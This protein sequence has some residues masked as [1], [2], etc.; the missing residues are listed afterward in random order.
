MFKWRKTSDLDSKSVVKS[1]QT[2]TILVLV[3]FTMM[4]FGVCQP[5]Q[6]GFVMPSGTAASVDGDKITSTEFRRAYI[7]YSNQLQQQYRDKFDPVALGVSVQVLN[8]LVD[9]AALYKEGLKS[10][11]Y[12][13]DEEI[14]HMIIDGEYFKDEKGGK[15]DPERFKMYLKS[16]G[17]TEATFTEELRREIVTNKFRGLITG[18]FQPSE[19]L[20]ELNYQLD[21]TKLDVEYVRID[22]N[23]VPIKVS[24]DDVD[25]FLKSGDAKIKEYYEANKGEFEQEQKVKARHVLI[26]YQGARNASGDAAKRSKAD[27]KALADKVLVE[28]RKTPDFAA[29][30]GKYTDEASGKNKGGDLGYFKKDQMVKEFA[31]AAFA[32]KPGDVSAV[33]ESPFG[34]H[35]IKVD[36]VQDAKSVKLD[37]AKR[38]IAEKLV[39]RDRRPQLMDQKVKD[40]LA[41]L[42]TDKGDEQLK[43]LGL[44]WKATGPFSIG[45]RFIPGLGADKATL[46]AVSSLKKVGE[47]YPSALDSTGAKFIVRLKSRTDADMTK[48]TAE[49]RQQLADSSR[50][51]DSYMLF[52]SLTGD[53]RKRYEDKGKIYRNPEYVNYDQLN[54]RAGE[55]E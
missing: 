50:Y 2:Y 33:V 46:K 22:P 43:D 34:F 3:M 35:I 15:F 45:A 44:S 5:T 53:I 41:A 31:D 29:L 17:H 12:A 52:N 4:F 1:W 16:Q 47:V 27:A 8:S 30:A 9:R 6:D 39:A 23:S 54:R 21:E 38:E 10:G 24:T 32:M 40:L 7:Q 28:A 20:A 42:Q 37:D 26:S 25:A 14:E 51:M 11:L 48:L 36:A 55:A 49:K 19:K 18:S 13:S